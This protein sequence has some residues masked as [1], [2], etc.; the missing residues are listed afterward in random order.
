VSDRVHF[1]G[2]VPDVAA[3]YAAADAF[4]LPT[5]YEAF[6][7]VSLEAAAAGLPL[8]ITPVSGVEDLIEDG[9]NGWFVERSASSI[10]ERLLELTDPQLRE[11]L[12]RSARKS[13][14]PYAWDGVIKRYLELYE[15]L[16]GPD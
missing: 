6:P 16:T 10:A 4:T 11:R 3:V 1:A 8:L 5:T 9:S 14:E 15:E 2:H 7:L 13:A 12:A